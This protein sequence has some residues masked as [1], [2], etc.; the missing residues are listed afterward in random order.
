MMTLYFRG[1]SGP[2]VKRLQIKLKNLGLYTGPIEGLFGGGTESA[3]RTFQRKRGLH[4]DGKVGQE[5]WAALF[6]G[7]TIP[8]PQITVEPLEK[9]CL[10]L[11]G[12]FESG[13]MIPESFSCLTG[14]FDGQGISLGIL[15]WN[16]G[17]QSLQPLLNEM[18]SLHG[19]ILKE[20]FGESHKILT[21][22]MYK[23]SFRDQMAWVQSIQS[24][25]HDF[26]EPWKGLFKTLGRN[27]AFQDIQIKH[28]SEAFQRAKKLC[29]EFGVRSERAIA[30]M[31]DVVVQNG[32]IGNETRDKINLDISRLAPDIPSEDLEVEKMRIVANRRAEASRSQ[33]RED[34][35]RRKLCCANGAGT[36]HGVDYDLEHQF[37]ICLR[38]FA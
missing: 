24:A 20:I 36:V 35:R 23:Y 25:R 8:A 31:F 15:Q 11:T 32:S 28:S 27:E 2:E 4:V 18:D 21:E 37:G 33:F 6:D 3:V 12:C 7:E 1:C 26:Y 10:A 30:L 29:R 17:Q 19:D 22:V 13:C 14:D 9:R 34:V 38:T 5:T 16:F